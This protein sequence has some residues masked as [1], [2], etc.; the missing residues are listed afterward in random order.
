[1]TGLLLL[2]ALAQPLDTTRVEVTERRSVLG[3]DVISSRDLESLD[4]ATLPRTEAADLALLT[5][6]FI[7]RAKR[8]GLL[9]QAAPAQR[10]LVLLDGGVDSRMFG[11]L[12]DGASESP[13]AMM[14]VAR[15]RSPTATIWVLTANQLSSDR[16]GPGCCRPCPCD[17]EGCDCPRCTALDCRLVVTGAQLVVRFT[18]EGRGLSREE[19]VFS[20]TEQPQRPPGPFRVAIKGEAVEPLHRAIEARLE[21]LGHCLHD[22]ERARLVFDAMWKTDGARAVGRL[23][24][25]SARPDCPPDA[26]ACVR[27]QR[28]VAAQLGALVTETPDVETA[29]TIMLLEAPVRD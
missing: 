11:A 2:I 4:R 21:K 8:H 10:A 9:V 14:A 1:M 15:L 12:L 25:L 23:T 3:P 13:Q 24:E 7:A 28:C 17:A 6:R 26:V 19:A 16:V 22:G 20:G 18:V 5:Q 27:L 29:V